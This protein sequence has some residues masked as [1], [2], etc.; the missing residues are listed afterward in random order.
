MNEGLTQSFAIVPPAIPSAGVYFFTTHSGVKYEVRFGRRKDNILHAT[1]VFGVINDEY[2][3]EEYV[4]TN[5]G[6][7][8]RVMATLVKVIRMF[9]R[10]HPKVMI[11]EFTGTAKE[12]E[13]DEGVNARIN[14]Y[15]RYLPVIFPHEEE[16]IFRFQGSNAVVTKKEKS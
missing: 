3:G 10:E 9:I 1:F 14:L 12:G 6:E 15:K 11:Y 7:V 13:P 8:Y 2:E 16:W 5:K 4:E